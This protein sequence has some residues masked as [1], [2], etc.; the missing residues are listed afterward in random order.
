MHTPIR[1]TVFA[2]FLKRLSGVLLG[3]LTAF[4]KRL[5]SACRTNI[6]LETTT[7]AIFFDHSYTKKGLLSLIM[8]Y[9]QDRHRPIYYHQRRQGQQPEECQRCHS[10][11]QAGGC[12]WFERKRQ[13]VVGVRHP[14]CRGTTPLCG[15]PQQLCTTIHGTHGQARGGHHRRHLSG[16]SHPTESQHFQSPFHRRHF[17]RDI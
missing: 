6:P 2:L 3:T 15:E 7:I 12:H 11:Q 10:T 16:S 13:I 17:D 5:T 14:L 4:L 9:V 1:L 8:T